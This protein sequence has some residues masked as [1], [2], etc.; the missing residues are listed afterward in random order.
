MAHQCT[1][2]NRHILHQEDKCPILSSF[3]EEGL[4][5]SLLNPGALQVPFPDFLFDCII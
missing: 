3:Q 1:T 2:E 4:G 5:S